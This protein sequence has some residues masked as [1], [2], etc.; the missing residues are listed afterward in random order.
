[1]GQLRAR[2]LALSPHCR[3][4]S[5]SAE[6]GAIK[7]Y[8]FHTEGSASCSSPPRGRLAKALPRESLWVHNQSRYPSRHPPQAPPSVN[9]KRADWNLL[10]ELKTH[11][12]LD[13]P[14]K[15]KA[16]H[17]HHAHHQSISRPQPEHLTIPL[18]EGESW[19]VPRLKMEWL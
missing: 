13:R 18:S 3:V 15:P 6:H 7:Q 17:L 12:K 1:M 16:H 2:G 19:L 14:L 11:T 5:L 9:F 10:L 8:Q 4:G